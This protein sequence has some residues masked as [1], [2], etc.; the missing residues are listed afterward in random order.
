M[1]EVEAMPASASSPEALRAAA[2]PITVRPERSQAS[3]AAASA[4][5]LPVP[6][7][8][9]TA[10]IRSRPVARR[11]HHLGL[12]GAEVGV[13]GEGGGRALRLRRRGSTSPR[14]SSAK[15]RSRSSRRGVVK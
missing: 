15:R 5:V 11:L 13:A 9:A 8:A 12:V 7:R 1:I 6:G 2:T 3:R 10:A 4:V 14:A